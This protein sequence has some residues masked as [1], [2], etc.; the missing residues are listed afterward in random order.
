[1]KKHTLLQA[2][3]STV[4]LLS[5]ACSGGDRD[6]DE[7]LP[8]LPQANIYVVGTNG[9]SETQ[10]SGMT[11]H[12][13]VIQKTD[14]YKLGAVNPRY[15]RRHTSVFRSGTDIYIAG[16]ERQPGYL[17]ADF[18]V[19]QL[20]DFQP[21]AM[22]WKND[23]PSFPL[24]TISDGFEPAEAHSVFVSGD[25]VYVGGWEGINAAPNHISDPH[26]KHLPTIWKNGVPQR[27]ELGKFFGGHVKSVFVHGDDVYAAGYVYN[28]QRYYT[29]TLWKNG[30]PQFLTDDSLYNSRADSV[31]VGPD[32]VVYV[33]GWRERLYNAVDGLPNPDHAVIWVNDR[34]Q[35]LG[36]AHYLRYSSLCVHVSDVGDVYVAGSGVVNRYGDWNGD[37]NTEEQPDN[38]YEV[39]LWKNGVPQRTLEPNYELHKDK[40]GPN[41]RVSHSIS[42]DSVYTFGDDVYVVGR[43]FTGWA[44]YNEDG[45]LLRSY[46]EINATLW[47]NGG[48]PRVLWSDWLAGATPTSDLNIRN[49]LLICNA[50]SVI[51]WEKDGN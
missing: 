29:A 48:K 47:I 41:S 16:I 35:I 24:N 44:Y 13:G 12:N 3:V 42:V 11:W 50:N 8:P 6:G 1:M 17:I 14:G 32:G 27:L 5:V 7:A 15:N 26:E 2:V 22:L 43:Q 23:E 10:V 39:L 33:A 51:V 45:S 30:V 37:W 25:D 40:E 28:Y 31:F 4:L 19:T 9:Y 21:K 34:P 18:G 20:Y 38:W 49:S 46:A 36:V